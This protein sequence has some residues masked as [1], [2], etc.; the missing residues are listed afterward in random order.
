[1]ET[2]STRLDP[3][4]FLLAYSRRMIAGNKKPHSGTPLSRYQQRNRERTILPV[5]QELAIAFAP[6]PTFLPA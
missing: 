5:L 3:T 1:M 2:Q 4:E 6:T